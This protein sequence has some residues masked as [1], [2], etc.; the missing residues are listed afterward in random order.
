MFFHKILRQFWILTPLLFFS[1]IFAPFS[2][3]LCKLNRCAKF[4]TMIQMVETGLYEL[5]QILDVKQHMRK[6]LLLLL[7]LDSVLILF[8]KWVHAPCSKSWKNIL[9]LKNNGDWK[10]YIDNKRGKGEMIFILKK[11][12]I[13]LYF[14]SKNNGIFSFKATKKKN[15]LSLLMNNC[16]TFSIMSLLWKK[17]IFIKKLCNGKFEPLFF[18]S[19]W[20]VCNSNEH[21]LFTVF[22]KH[23]VSMHYII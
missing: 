2:F 14:V 13:I 8:F 19:T 1:F 20:Y 15:V 9:S 6:T 18:Y 17:N 3:I 21:Q 5:K 4:E 23:R 11:L 12:Y 16:T 22:Y 10:L 7:I